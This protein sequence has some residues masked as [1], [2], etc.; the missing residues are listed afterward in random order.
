MKR[1]KRE[2]VRY[3]GVKLLVVVP[4]KPKPV[5]PYAKMWREHKE[6]LQQFFATKHSL[7]TWAGQRYDRFPTIEQIV[8]DRQEQLGF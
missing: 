6:V 8:T 1:I 7:Y 3:G 5:P 2:F 4:P